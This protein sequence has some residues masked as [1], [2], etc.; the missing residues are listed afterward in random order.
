[1]FVSVRVNSELVLSATGLVP[2]DFATLMALPTVNV[3]PAA[4]PARLTGPVAVGVLVVLLFVLVAVTPCVMVQVPPGVIVPAAKPTLV[5]PLTP[6]ERVALP[7]P[8]QMTL[9]VALFCRV[10]V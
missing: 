9:P 3:A 5:P 2:N 6:P 8:E 7:A 10:S 4:N 1:M